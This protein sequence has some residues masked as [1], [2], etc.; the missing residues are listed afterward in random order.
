[1]K[2]LGKAGAQITLKKQK[3]FKELTQSGLLIPTDCLF[4]S[5]GGQRIN[6][7]EF[8]EHRDE[9]FN[10][11][12]ER[13][14]KHGFDLLSKPVTVGTARHIRVRP[15]F[16]SW[17]VSGTINISAEEFDLDKLTELFEKAGYL[18]LGDW[19]PGCKNPGNHG[20][21]EASIKIK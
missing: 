18:G 4:F 19:R 9:K 15:M 2:C 1:M 16:K 3:T 21:F 12:V 8:V 13:T 5:N 6:M 14:R 17:E 11:Q 20:M 7:T 10:L